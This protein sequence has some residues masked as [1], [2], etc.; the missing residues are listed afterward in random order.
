MDRLSRPMPKR[1]PASCL[2]VLPYTGRHCMSRPGCFA[3][4]LLRVSRTSV[5]SAPYPAIVERWP[6][7]HPQ[8]VCVANP[9]ASPGARAIHEARK[10]FSDEKGSDGDQGACRVLLCLFW[11]DLFH[12]GAKN[13]IYFLS[14]ILDVS[15]E[16]CFLLAFSTRQSSHRIFAFI[17][18]I[19]EGT[20]Q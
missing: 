17:Q 5:A 8:E 2:A 4:H 13:E 9:D 11:A 16:T 14:M 1:P 12:C 6:R 19:S 20:S 18:R 15:Q 7:A 10:S 3:Q